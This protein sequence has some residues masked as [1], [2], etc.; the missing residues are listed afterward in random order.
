MRGAYNTSILNSSN[1][2]LLETNWKKNSNIIGTAPVVD[3]SFAMRACCSLVNKMYFCTR[4]CTIQ[5]N[6]SG[7]PDYG[8][9][10]VEWQFLTTGR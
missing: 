10:H 1:E 3:G 9:R 7:S 2:C 5:K 8:T 6:M 4:A